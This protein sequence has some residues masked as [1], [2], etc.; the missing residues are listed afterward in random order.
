MKNKAIFVVFLVM[1]VFALAKTETVK[2]GK[3][4]SYEL[5]D[6]NI[7][8][9]T[10]DEEDD[11]VILCVNGERA[12]V[13]EDRDK[14]VN[15]LLIHIR[16][17]KQS[18]AKLEISRTCSGSKCS[19]EKVGEECDNTPC[20]DECK[21]NSECDDGDVNTN[22]FCTGKPKKCVNNPIEGGVDGGEGEGVG[23]EGGEVEVE[24]DEAEGGDKENYN[25]L[26]TALLS[27][28]IIVLVIMIFKKKR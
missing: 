19:C 8:V 21:E 24:S 15:G 7:T 9:I 11:K 18:Y 26:F 10:Y 17:V 5:K 16:E 14:T 20:F 27:I 6:K 3:M 13:S 4:D 28:F 1:V 22:D 25:V 2:F 12:I 23:G